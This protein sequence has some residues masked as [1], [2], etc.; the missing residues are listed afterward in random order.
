[1]R[2]TLSHRARRRWRRASLPSLL[3]TVLLVG[4]WAALSGEAADARMIMRPPPPPFDPRVLE[5]VVTR[6]H[7][8]PPISGGTLTTLRERRLLVSDPDTDRVMVLSTDGEPRV[9][10][11]L[12]EARG[13]EPA[14]AIED[15]AGRV[16]VLLRGRGE[17]L[18]FD[19]SATSPEHASLSRHAVCGMPRGLV[20][21]R[22]RDRLI[23]ACRGGELVWVSPSDGSIVR[24]SRVEGDL[25]DVVLAGDRLIVTRFR[26]AEALVVDRDD[27]HVVARRNV[28]P[29]VENETT[30]SAAV[31][32]RA[33]ALPSGDVAMLHQRERDDEVVAAPGGYGGFGGCD[34]IVKSTISVLAGDTLRAGPILAGATLPV[35]LAARVEDGHVTSFAVVAA[36][37]QNG[38]RSVLLLPSSALDDAGCTGGAMVPSTHSLANAIAVSYLE[39]G[40]LAVQARAPGRVVI[41]DPARSTSVQASLGGPDTFDTGHAVFHAAT[42]GHIACASCH[43]EGG[44]DGHVWRFSGLGPR[45]TPALHDVAGTAPFHWEGD[46]ADVDALAREVFTG[47]MNGVDLPSTHTAALEGWLGH[48]RRP[49]PRA[50][51]GARIARGRA[52]FEG[53]GGCA[54]CHDGRHLS[55]GRSHDVGTGRAF[56]TPSLRGVSDRLPV[57]HDGCAH[58]LRER[59]SPSCG[60]ADHGDAVEGEALEDLLAYLESL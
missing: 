6:P 12:D 14:R 34:G 7:G 9:T 23:V 28:A 16:H 1:M 17:L 2:A 40:R 29:Q 15:A 21:D 52:V 56:Q 45:R 10:L 26:S 44:E 43:P 11:E 5:R 49:S 51:D 54:E 25:R 57:M 18:S 38:D 19:P 41:V 47:R 31:A 32:W 59:F 4:L 37:N 42:G 39:D 46:L 58:T 48:L 8:P 60:G 55:D 27:G 53:A 22:A 35:D 24:T 33:I 50:G 36:G 20:L 3:L 13:S 30:S